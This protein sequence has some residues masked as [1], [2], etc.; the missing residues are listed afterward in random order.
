M[1]VKWDDQTPK[2][3]STLSLVVEEKRVARNNPTR[4]FFEFINRRGRVGKKKA[5]FPR[6]G[7]VGEKEVLNFP[8]RGQSRL[9][10]MYKFLTKMSQFLA[11][12]RKISYYFLGGG[13]PARKNL[14]FRPEEFLQSIF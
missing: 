12:A 6:Q 2:I 9:S 3:R 5:K 7:R 11:M 1:H 4:K 13:A 8:R 10:K 14:V